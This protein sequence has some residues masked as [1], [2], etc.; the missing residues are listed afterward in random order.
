MT[1]LNNPL[2]H[3][4]IRSASLDWLQSERQRQIFSISETESIVPKNW[5]LVNGKLSHIS[6]RF[7]NIVGIQWNS[8]ENILIHAPFIDQWE[9]G[10]LAIAICQGRRNIELLL[11]AKFEPGN[12]FGIDLAPTF[13]ATKSNQD[14]VHNGRPTHLKELFLD[15]P[16]FLS[17]SNQSEQGTRFLNKWNS[18]ALLELEKKID[19]PPGM[20]WL[21]FSDVQTA[22]LT[23]HTV[24]TDAR[25][26]LACSNWSLWTKSSLELFSRLPGSLRKPAIKSLSNRPD[27]NL[28][29][30][31]AKT[32]K[33]HHQIHNIPYQTRP[34]VEMEG[35]LIVQS[36]G[37]NIGIEIINLS[38]ESLSREVTHWEQPLIKSRNIS[39]E[40]LVGKVENQELK[41]L[42]RPV[43][44]IGYKFQAQLGNSFR[45]SE[46][47]RSSNN[48][49]KEWITIQTIISNSKRL[50]SI[51]QSDEGGR[52]YKQVV[53]YELL[54]LEKQDKLTEI[55][56]QG[57][58]LSISNINMLSSLSGFFTNEARTTISL[59]LGF[60]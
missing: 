58:W 48:N 45:F 12:I 16:N 34:I 24:N 23:S 3:D 38:V 41:F 21:T 5:R 11:D 50:A 4:N 31:L 43:V 8:S 51:D 22:L 20:R 1:N 56:F 33:S 28:P 32:L 42:F 36:T 59:I 17:F 47:E 15:S 18:N 49:N 6:G 25:S 9:I 29:K 52:F 40:I 2:L 60:I 10:L 26:I 46:A 55:Q 27:K 39:T 30:K 14:L 57:T 35:S 54:I 13:Q 19:P 37:K 53:R 44:E 7:F